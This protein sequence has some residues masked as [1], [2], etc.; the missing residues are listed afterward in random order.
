MMTKLKLLEGHMDIL[1]IILLLPT[2]AESSADSQ[3]INGIDIS[4]FHF[5]VFFG[6]SVE[7]ILIPC[8]HMHLSKGLD[9]VKLLR[10]VNIF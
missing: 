10:S 5:D 2:Y 6:N 8:H 1:Q 9:F 4:F 3:S 7:T